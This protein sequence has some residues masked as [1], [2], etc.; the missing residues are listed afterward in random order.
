MADT[1]EP[2][3]HASEGASLTNRKRIIA[4]LILAAIVLAAAIAVPR[5]EA[6]YLES[7]GMPEIEGTNVFKYR[8]DLQEYEVTEGSGQKFDPTATERAREVRESSE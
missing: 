3:N 5:I 8:R 4:Y 2:I 7:M 6:A 1:E